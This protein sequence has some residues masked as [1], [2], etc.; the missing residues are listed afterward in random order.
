MGGDGDGGDGGGALDSTT[1]ADGSTADSSP[2]SESGL[3]SAAIDAPG[4]EG[5]THDA[6]VSDAAAADVALDVAT[7]PPPDAMV[8]VPLGTYGFDLDPN[9]SG[10][11][12]V[13]ASVA[14]TSAFAIDQYEVT[15]GR[16]RAWVDAGLPVPDA[17]SLDPGGPYANVMVWSSSWNQDAQDGA[18]RG[19]GT[20]GCS[21]E[22]NALT[23]TYL[24]TS[25]SAAAFPVTC[26]N[27][28]QSVAFCAFEGKRLPTEAEW[29]VVAQGN[30][31][32]TKYPWGNG[33]DLDDSCTYAIMS[34][35]GGCGFPVPVGSA[36]MGRTPSGVYDLS[37]SVS[38]RFWDRLPASAG[39]NY[40]YPAGTPVNYAG[41]APSV[42][43]TDEF[44]AVESYYLG[45]QIPYA[46]EG[47]EAEW[48]GS[49]LPSPAVM[50]FRCAKS[51][52]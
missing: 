5:A 29:R 17:G 1:A 39:G 19:Q 48:T 15:V 30:G 4:P 27:W 41:P 36:P 8:V 22:P 3:D 37:G 2:P 49:L 42:Q 34:D 40:T 28:F 9:G 44:I 24:S 52:P 47:F 20:N 38:E 45:P 18:F 32:R 10:H 16:F 13:D 6:A 51:L 43:G 35:D 11:V 46:A 50:G 14:F 25:P 7:G 33:P 31:Q 21:V 12:T 23:P 26:V